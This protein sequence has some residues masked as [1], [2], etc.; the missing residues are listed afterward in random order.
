MP[1][2]FLALLLLLVLLLGYWL[3]RGALNRWRD[4]RAAVTY[5]LAADLRP[6]VLRA[7]G[8]MI[9]AIFA[10]ALAV[11]VLLGGRGLP[12]LRAGVLGAAGAARTG[13][14]GPAAAHRPEAPPAA[15]GVNA[16]A[17]V[18]SPSNRPSA[19]ASGSASASPSASAAPTGA[20]FETVSRPAEGELLQGAVLAGDG[21][22]RTVRVWLPPHYA[23]DPTARFPV[24]VLQAAGPGRTADSEI[25]DVFDGISS[26]IKTG[27]S[28]PF[29][30][31]AP[32]GPKGTA[33]PC[34]L[35][36]AAPQALADDAR[37]RAAVAAAF[38]TLPPGP[39]GWA[40][41]GVDGGAPCAAAAG[42]A[43]GD[44]YGAAAAVSG[45][46]DAAALAQAASDAPSGAAPQLLLAAAKGDADGLAAA[47]QV[48]TT[49]HGGKGQA[50]RA[51][52]KTSDI[53]EDYAPD[54]E[55]LRLVRI[56]AQYLAETLA[57]PAG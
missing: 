43:R 47:R 56:A 28:R 17:A 42:L 55:R 29:V 39:Q 52:V 45:R 30:V 32:E 19:S 14:V 49:L 48:L 26:A 31:V 46:Y 1:R 6:T 20:R 8:A 27:R 44:L 50:A 7:G 53:V 33:H 41:L 36:A 2:P 4:Q 16:A 35:V 25:P 54:R 22:P 9:C 11:A 10:T 57:H 34:D 21:K 38:R 23:D 13:A 5:E 51:V 37:M 3:A 18:A 12:G 24:I 15:G 40:A